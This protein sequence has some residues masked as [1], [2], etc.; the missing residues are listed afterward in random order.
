M[1]K[2]RHFLEHQGC[3][4]TE[5][6]ESIVRGVNY[7]RMLKHGHTLDNQGDA[8]A[9]E[10]YERGREESHWGSDTKEMQGVT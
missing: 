6:L 1:L 4:V 7:E 10:G 2:Y 8:V 9:K 3:M 5:G